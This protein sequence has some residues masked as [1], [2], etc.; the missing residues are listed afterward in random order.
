MSK[1]GPQDRIKTAIA[2]AAER[3]SLEPRRVIDHDV[4]VRAGDLYGAFEE[5][6][7]NVGP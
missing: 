6:E 3:L 5:A 1:L 4:P 2:E 7:E